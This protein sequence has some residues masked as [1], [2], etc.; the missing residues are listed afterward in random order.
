MI[1]TISAA[2]DAIPCGMIPYL[3]RIQKVMVTPNIYTITIR[4]TADIFI[5]HPDGTLTTTSAKGGTYTATR[6][7]TPPY[8]GA[9]YVREYPTIHTA[10]V[11]GKSMQYKGW[12]VQESGLTTSPISVI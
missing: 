10:V 6:T 1:S 11:D 5:I 4:D 2:P 12:M 3:M 8:G 7:I 9:W